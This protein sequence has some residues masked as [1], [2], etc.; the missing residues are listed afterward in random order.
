MDLASS[1]ELERVGP[2]ALRLDLESGIWIDSG[3]FG[4]FAEFA[5]G[6]WMGGLTANTFEVM[7]TY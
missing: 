5:F 7:A 1:R 2:F 4:V 3:R 6:C